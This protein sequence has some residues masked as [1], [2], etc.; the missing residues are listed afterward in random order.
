MNVSPLRDK[1][2]RNADMV[3]IS[4]IVAQ[5]QSVAEVIA[6]C[7]RHGVR[8][9]AGGP[10][11][12]TTH[13]EYKAIDHFVLDEA[14]LTLPQFL[15]DLKKGTL[16]HIYRA[17][18]RADITDT[19][20]PRWDLI[21][22]RQYASM[23]IQ[24]SRGCPFNCEFCDITF[25]Y[26]RESRT[27]RTEQVLTELDRLY[28]HGWRGAVFFVDDNFIGNKEKL[29]NEVLPA[30][31]R[32]MEQKRHPF[33]FNTQASI[34]IAD[35]KELMRMMTEAGFTTVFIG[36][37]SPSE[38]SLAECNKTQNR[39]RDLLSCIRDIQQH[40]LEVQGGFIIG[41]DSDSPAIFEK[42]I[43]FIQ[44][45]GIVT[46]MVGLLN[47]MKGTKLYQRMETE[48]RLLRTESGDN[49]DGSINFLPR[50]GEQVL[51]EGYRKVVSTIYT[52]RHYYL[53]VRKYMEQF[54]PSAT[55]HFVIQFP[56]IMAFLK[57][58]FL[59]GILAKGRVYYWKLV[60]WTLF[61]NPRL[62]P[63]AVTFAIYG[64]HYR[65]VF[66]RHGA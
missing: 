40:G 17:A 3:F 55:R 64:Y 25:L 56:H 42:Q 26:W 53:R 33:I 60:L 61:N 34:N 31:S 44:E 57:S 20:V 37:E 39:R 9:V 22:M 52:P 27:K 35:D 45:S 58:M 49:T 18:S 7:K 21:D 38:E 50:M 36:I 24:Y 10:L 5:K 23:N 41:F 48:N 30:I 43:S 54:V 1:D 66:E 6:R 8:T 2:I 59:L 19:P 29:K 16:R 51:R 62:F 65:K 4:A 12:T 13:E 11:F 32:W 63:H 14:E 28:H 47:A 46:A 15:D